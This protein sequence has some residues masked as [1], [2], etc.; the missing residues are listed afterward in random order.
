MQEVSHPLL[1]P[2]L[3]QTQCRGK[4]WLRQLWMLIMVVKIMQTACALCVLMHTGVQSLRLVA[5]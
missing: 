5:M 2:L 1:P 3:Q 4:L